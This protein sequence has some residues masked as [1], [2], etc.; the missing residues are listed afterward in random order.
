MRGYCS[1]TVVKT[2]KYIVHYL[3]RFLQKGRRSGT[4]IENYI[5]DL[6]LLLFN[7]LLLILYFLLL[8][9]SN[10]FIIIIFLL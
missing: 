1:S 3:E 5:L 2:K 4:D 7:Y 8:V 6:L 9:L 10:L